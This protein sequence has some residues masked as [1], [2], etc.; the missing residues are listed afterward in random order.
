M[1]SAESR[2]NSEGRFGWD[3]GEGNGHGGAEREEG[4]AG[5]DDG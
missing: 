2:E 3:R 4:D 5:D 1:D